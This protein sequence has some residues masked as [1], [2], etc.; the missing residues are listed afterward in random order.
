VLFGTYLLLVRTWDAFYALDVLIG[1][2]VLGVAV[3]LAAARISRAVVCWSLWR[4]RRRSSQVLS[5]SGIATGG[6]D[7]PTRPLILIQM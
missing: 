6:R 1:L 4:R 3:G 7:G 2:L 5:C